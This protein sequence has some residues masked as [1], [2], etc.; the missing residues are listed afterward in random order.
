MQ[1]MRTDLASSLGLANEITVRGKHYNALSTC[2][3]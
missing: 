2:G 3:L 1:L